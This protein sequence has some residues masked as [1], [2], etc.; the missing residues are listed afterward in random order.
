MHPFEKFRKNLLVTFY[1]T[2]NSNCLIHELKQRKILVWGLWQR[3]TYEVLDCLVIRTARQIGSKLMHPFEKFRKNLLVTFYSTK[4]S[5]CL[6]HE[7]KQ[8]KILVWGLWQCKTYEVLDPVMFSGSS[9]QKMSLF[10]V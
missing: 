7:L 6:I 1:S 8:R 4:N 10:L 5:N 2:K 3:K 9:K